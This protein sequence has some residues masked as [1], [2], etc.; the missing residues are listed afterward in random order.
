MTADPLTVGV[1][2]ASGVPFDP[3]AS[4]EIVR[5]YAVDAAAQ[6]CRLVLFPEAFIG[7]YP[8]GITF[9]ATIGRRESDGREWFR[10]YHAAAVEIDGPQVRRLELIAAETRAT[11]IVG[12]I[13]RAGGTL[14]CAVVWVDPDRG[15]IGTRRKLLPTAA[16]RIVWG[17]GDLSQPT[18][19]D[20]QIGPVGVAICWEN[21]MPMLRT[22]M[23]S[24]G[25]RIWCAPT[26]DDREGWEATMRHIALEGRCFVLSAN[27]F[28]RRGDYPDDYP[29]DVPADQ[30]LSTGASMIVDPLGR[31]L[32]GPE[33]AGEQLMVATL[34][35]DE[36]A[37]AQMDFDV[38]GHYA[39]GDLF[40]LEVNTRSQQVVHERL[41]GAPPLAAQTAPRSVHPTPTPP[42]NDGADSNGLHPCTL[43]R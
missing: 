19:V 22:Y 7:G 29:L 43:V 6:G 23:Y 30:V 12:I 2:Q 14:Y 13:E 4:V 27:Q 8:R 5:Q 21:Y 36:I 20:T 11:L 31:V 42:A 15:V 32:A 24:Q 41:G 9:G 38:V 17:Q 26:A 18:V 39:R 37:R 34:D 28:I 33:R 25:V 40:S 35:L 1:V 16:E 10:R 3:D